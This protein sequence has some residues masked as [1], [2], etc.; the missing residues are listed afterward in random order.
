MVKGIIRSYYVAGGVFNIIIALGIVFFYKNC[1]WQGDPDALV[2]FWGFGIIACFAAIVNFIKA[3][4][5]G[6]FY[7]G[8][9]ELLSGR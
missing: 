9:K 5:V 3:G 1:P 2:W 6:M 4:L 8:I 7:A